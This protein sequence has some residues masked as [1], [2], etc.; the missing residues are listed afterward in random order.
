MSPEDRDWVGHGEHGGV[1][2]L[3]V[4][5]AD[6]SLDGPRGG[7]V[8]LGVDVHAVGVAGS[9]GHREEHLQDA[10][11]LM[12]KLAKLSNLLTFITFSPYHSSLLAKN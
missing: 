12:A 6:H 5:T 9:E 2:E 8:G 3:V 4:V 10:G 11:L 1:G 7:L